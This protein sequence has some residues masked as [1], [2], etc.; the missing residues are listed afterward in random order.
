MGEET[1]LTHSFGGD[2]AEKAWWREYM[3]SDHIIGEHEA[4]NGFGNAARV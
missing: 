2:V 3:E 4:E 1:V